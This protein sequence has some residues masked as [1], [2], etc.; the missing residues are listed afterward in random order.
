MTANDWIYRSFQR[1]RD[2]SS[3]QSTGNTSSRR[4]NDVNN[5]NKN[6]T[7]WDEGNGNNSSRRGNGNASSSRVNRLVDDDELPDLD[8]T[9]AGGSGQQGHQP[10]VN[11]FSEGVQERIRERDAAREI[12]A[13]R[14]THS[15]RQKSSNSNATTAPTMQGRGASSRVGGVMLHSNQ[16]VEEHSKAIR[17]QRVEVDKE[18]QLL[19]ADHRKVMKDSEEARNSFNREIVQKAENE[20]LLAEKAVAMADVELR[21][22]KADLN[23]SLLRQYSA[24]VET[25]VARARYNATL[26]PNAEKMPTFKIPMS[27]ELKSAMKEY[28]AQS[29]RPE[30]FEF[31]P[32]DCR[33]NY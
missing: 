12:H 8:G 30:T 23:T 13:K 31:V 3:G 18:H 17:D 27:D 29:S 19:L 24:M 7:Q 28:F 1:R 15:R 9:P 21:Q 5:V 14:M 4:D 16:V 11:E 25:Q 10:Q 6:T 32:E 22:K 2:N 26:P 33:N 20:R